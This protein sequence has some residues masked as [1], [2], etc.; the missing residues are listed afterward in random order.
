MGGSS[1]TGTAE[2]PGGSR[3]QP[4]TMATPTP[5]STKCSVSGQPVASTATSQVTAAL[6]SA[7]QGVQDPPLAALR[8][9]APPVFCGLIASMMDL[10]PVARPSLRLALDMI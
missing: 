8:H 4:L 10:D 6:L 3:Q 9:D 1:G 5:S 2:S 7:I